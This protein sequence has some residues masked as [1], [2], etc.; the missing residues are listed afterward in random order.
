M[1]VDINIFPAV[2]IVMVS[3]YE[4]SGFKTVGKEFR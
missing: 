3:I 4:P 2:K 1:S